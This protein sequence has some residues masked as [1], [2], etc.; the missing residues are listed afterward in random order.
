MAA[1]RI[2]GLIVSVTFLAARLSSTNDESDL[3]RVGL[4][5]VTRTAM[6]FG[7]LFHIAHNPMADPDQ[8]HHKGLAPLLAPFM[9][10]VERT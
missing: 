6:V 2:L 3:Q 8:K 9:I 10:K 5:L 1:R 4:R 7:L